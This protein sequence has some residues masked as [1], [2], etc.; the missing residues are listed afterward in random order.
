MEKLTLYNGTDIPSVGY[1]TCEIQ[2]KKCISEAIDCGY[3]LID[4]AS[5][6]YNEK[7]VGQAIRESKINRE[8]IIVLTKLWYSDMGYESTLQAFER[9]LDELQLSYID[10]YL[11]HWPAAEPKYPEW[12]QVNIETWRALEKIYL[13]GK[14]KGI[15]TCNFMKKHLVELLPHCEIKPMINQIESH[16]GFY[17]AE[18]AN[19]CKSQ[20][21]GL[22]AWGPL[23][24]GEVLEN[25]L[26]NELATKYHKSAAQICLRWN[27][28]NG[29][30]VIPKT[31]STNRMKE[32]LDIFDFNISSN[33]MRELSN[34]PFCGGEGAIVK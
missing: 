7:I 11:I 29:F 20:G 12:K 30:V 22:M 17:H 10:L 1:G 15:G 4:T 13:S 2:D 31:Q 21:I 8:E 23:G 6:Y 18:T 34:L 27:L 33:D 19:F 14:V 32:N 16:P 28:Q 3:R 24:T 5:H 9:S 25:D 26:I